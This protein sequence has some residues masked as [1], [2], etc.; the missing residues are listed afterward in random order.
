MRVLGTGN[1]YDLSTHSFNIN[2]CLNLPGSFK[3]WDAGGHKAIYAAKKKGRRI[4]ECR[5]RRKGLQFKIE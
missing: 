4:R 5:G 3:Y 1:Y 2:E